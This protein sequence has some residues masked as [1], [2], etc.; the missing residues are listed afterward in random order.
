MRLE[1]DVPLGGLQ[2]PFKHVQL[3]QDS[4]VGGLPSQTPALED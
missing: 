2:R 4:T 3:I 1:W